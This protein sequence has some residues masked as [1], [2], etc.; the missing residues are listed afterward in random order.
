M[1]EKQLDIT[2]IEQFTPEELPT[3][4]HTGTKCIR[5]SCKTPGNYTSQSTA[6]LPSNFIIYLNF[7][8]LLFIDLGFKC[9][10]YIRSCQS[11]S[12]AMM[13]IT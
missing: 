11:E 7:I 5:T 10:Q 13:S 3:T 1:L 9:T 12:T 2:V 6:P 8:D 4:V